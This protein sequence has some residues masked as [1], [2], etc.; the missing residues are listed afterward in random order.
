MAEEQLSPYDATVK[1]MS[2]ITSAIIGITLVLVA[3]FVPMAFFPGLDR[4]HLPPVLRHARD[5]DRV[6]GA[7]GADAHAGA[8]RD[9]A[10]A[11]VAEHEADVAQPASAPPSR[12]FFGWFNGWFARTT[13]RYQAVRR[14][15]PAPAAALP[16]PSSRARSP[17][18]LVLFR[19]LPGQLPPGRGPGQRA[20]RGAGAAGRDDRAHQRRD[21]A[22]EGVLS[23]AAADRRRRSSCAASASSARARR[24]R[25]RSCAL[26]AVGRAAG[27][28]EQRARR[29]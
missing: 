3:V 6:L 11:A 8:V 14:A 7:D 5:L 24:T 15:D 13:G 1:A 27:R 2:Q 17:I 22:G 18:T 28:G 4:R 19:R 10:Q 20:H 12:A 26:Q 29:S 25:W 16:R 21:R 23:R 9:A